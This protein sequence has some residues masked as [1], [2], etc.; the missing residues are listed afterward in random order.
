VSGLKTGDLV[1]IRSAPSY[2]PDVQ[3]LARGRLAQARRAAGLSSGEFAEALTAMLGWRV[4]PQLV[5]AWETT[6]EPP[7][8]ALLAAGLV[9]RSEAG[10]AT[11]PAEQAEWGVS[12]G[13][14]HLSQRQPE[15][16]GS[17]IGQASARGVQAVPLG[18]GT[19]GREDDEMNRRE[20]LRTLSVAGAFLGLPPLDGTGASGPHLGGSA[21]LDECETLNTHLWQVFSL[22]ASKQAV[23]PLVR[24][25]AGHLT[26]ALQR[27]HDTATHARLCTLAADLFQ[28]AGEV[29]FDANRYTDAGYCYTL[30]ASAGRE[31]GAYDLWACA[32][33]RHAYVSLYAH[34]LEE[35]VAVLAAA[36]RLAER[37]DSQL[38]TRYWVAAVQAEAF[39]RLGRLG[40]CDRALDAAEEVHHLPGP[41][42]GGWLRF[43][44]S[45]LPEQRGTCY[46]ELGRYDPAADALTSSLA[47]RLSLRRR[48]SVL[49]DL[50]VLGVHRRDSE[51]VLEYASAAVELAEHTGSGYVGRRLQG[52]QAKLRPLLSDRRVA[53]LDHQITATTASSAG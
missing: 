22:S 45:R 12:Q 24:Q 23:Y 28:L 52:L 33:T 18:D 8:S 3:A 4:T 11:A 7:G 9:T 25:Q 27:P 40:S 31:A 10:G 36:A 43:D 49:T 48:G 46:V 53:E 21:G 29:F 1:D 37:G 39:A 16:R 38:P 41:A 26:A 19:G 15:R 2:R 50:A 47:G 6:A 44:G 14:G 13:T 17:E 20:L 34:R 51:Q 5:D 32:L 35:T 30:A 42:Q